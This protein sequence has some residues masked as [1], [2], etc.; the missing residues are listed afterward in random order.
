MTELAVLTQQHVQ[1][2][3][4]HD[5]VSCSHPATS[6][7]PWNTLP[8]QLCLPSNIFHFVEHI[9]KSAVL[10]QQHFPLH[11]AHYQVSCVSPTTHIKASLHRTSYQLGHPFQ[12]CQLGHRFQSTIPNKT[13][14][15]QYTLPSQL[16]PA[17]DTHTKPSLHRTAYQLGHPFQSTIPNKTFTLQ[18][19][20]PSQPFP[21]TDTH[22]K[23]SLYRTHCRSKLF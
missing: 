18:H 15:L 11:W 1:H 2:R 20:L 14:T 17:T 4:T 16:F 8:S 10:T 6:S 9:T 22:T 3:G 12:F 5:R 13:F 19:T 21:A 23:P 7:T